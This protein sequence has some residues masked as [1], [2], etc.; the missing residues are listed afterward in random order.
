MSQAAKPEVTLVDHKALYLLRIADKKLIN[1]N[2]AKF[3][4]ELPSEN[5]ILG[6]KSGQHFYIYA[7]INGVQVSRKY[8]P[9][10]LE[11]H[12][13][14]FEMIIKIYRANENEDYPNGGIMTQYLEKLAPGDFISIQ[15]PIGRCVYLHNGH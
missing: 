9:L 14:T 12:K 5:H 8:T 11:D 13:G 7:T 10:D 2:V 3:V 15:G 6:T 1:H 4:V